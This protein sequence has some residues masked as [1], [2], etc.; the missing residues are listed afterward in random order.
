MYYYSFCGCII[1]TVDVVIIIPRCCLVSSSLARSCIGCSG[2]ALLLRSFKESSGLDLGMCF[3]LCSQTAKR[4]HTRRF[5]ARCFSSKKFHSLLSCLLGLHPP[6]RRLPA[7]PWRGASL[8]LQSLAG[9]L[10]GRPAT[11]GG[12]L[13]PITTK[14][15]T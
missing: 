2:I 10:C 14:C 6:F 12:S 9:W 1:I 8:S 5:C 4:L 7:S 15:S 11:V 13:R 3:I